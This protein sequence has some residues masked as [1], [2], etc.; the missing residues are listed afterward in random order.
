MVSA[1]SRHVCTP[2]C[3]QLPSQSPLLGPAVQS[4]RD[5]ALSD[6]RR[7]LLPLI[8]IPGG[9]EAAKCVIEPLVPLQVW[10]ALA[11]KREIFLLF[12]FF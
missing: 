8:G 9:R 4:R 6:R 3:Y 10:T 2:E 1:D 11:Q 12:Y 5:L 7:N